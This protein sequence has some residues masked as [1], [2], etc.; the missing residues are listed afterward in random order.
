MI[1]SSGND[2]LQKQYQALLD[3]YAQALDQSSPIP[4]L[5]PEVLSPPPEIISPPVSPPSSPL[6]FKILFYF[7]LLTFLAVV[8][9]I[10]YSFSKSQPPSSV[11]SPTPIP[12]ET[13]SNPVC[14][15]N[16]KTYQIGESFPAADGCNTCACQ[17]DQLIIC[18]EIACEATPSTKLTPTKTSTGYKKYQNSVYSFSFEYP[19]TFIVVDELPKNKSQ[20]GPKTS[21]ELKDTN[22]NYTVSIVVDPAG[23]GPIFADKM[24]KLTYSSAKGLY[25][26]ETTLASAADVD[27]LSPEKNTIWYQFDT[28]KYSNLTIISTAPKV[29][30]KLENILSTLLSTFKFL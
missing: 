13:K 22:N 7:S 12:T 4:P 30:I 15:L 18:T 23:F 24:I 2:E 27:Y 20:G 21:L 26:A 8:A 3:Q 5:P 19:N 17:P 25:A 10:V 14:E 9:A 29:D 6:F 11:S 1:D 16:D 28:D